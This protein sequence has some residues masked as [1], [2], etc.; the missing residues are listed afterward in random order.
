MIK[1][2]RIRIIR[3]NEAN[4]ILEKLNQCPQIPDVREGENIF[5]K[6]GSR[7]QRLGE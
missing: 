4:T 2:N 3:G 6:T 7:I 1:M 5:P